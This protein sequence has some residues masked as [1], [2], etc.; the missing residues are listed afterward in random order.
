MSSDFYVYAYLDPRKPGEYKYG[1]L[2]FNYEPFYIGKGR[3]NRINQHL[4]LSRTKIEKNVVKARTIKK[5]LKMGFDLKKNFIV[6]IKENI[7]EDES[8]ALEMQYVKC[9]G[10]KNIKT[11]P[12]LN[13][14]DGGD[15]C[16]GM[17]VR[18]ETRELISRKNKG[19][20]IKEETRKKNSINNAKYWTGKIRSKK[21]IK[22][23]KSARNK[24]PKYLK[25]I[26]N[27]IIIDPNGKEY[28]TKN[29]LSDFCK[30]H[31]LQRSKMVLVA[32]G[33]R[34]HHRNWIC[35]Y[36]E[37]NNM[38][39]SLL[40][41]DFY[42]FT[43]QQL[44]FH[45]FHNVDV[46]YEFKC[47]SEKIDFA[48]YF[49]EIKEKINLLKNLTLTSREDRFMRKQFVFKNNY[50]DFI[51]RYNNN[52]NNIETT[53]E[54][55]G[56]LKIVISG[57]WLNTV[58]LEV[59]ILAIVNEIYFKDKKHDF[60]IGMERLQKKVDL[61]KNIK[62]FKFADFGT[63][64]RL[65]YKWQEKVIEFLKE[66]CPDNFIGTSN[67]HFAHKYD[68]KPIGTMSHQLI[69][70]HQALVRVEDSQK[71]A[72][73]N[74]VKEYE[75]KLGIAL[76]DTCGIDAFLKDFSYPLASVYSGIRQDSGDPFV[77]AEK[78]IEHYKSLGIDPKTKTIVF[79]DGL[80]FPL[81][82]KLYKKFK[83]EIN[84]IFGIGTD[85]T[86]AFQHEP[87]QIVIKMVSC[88]N[89][90][91]AKISEARGKTMCNDSV[92]LAYLK[93]VFNIE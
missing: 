56:E 23:L 33:K 7:T 93:N 89:Q 41:N 90:P 70:A 25:K 61:I 38:I 16:S 44:I 21:T 18:K 34:K 40:D 10:R 31:G 35:K 53:L 43:Q 91:V 17:L 22:A 87:L 1:N 24:Q 65:S 51:D 69:M 2:T 76:S 12:L 9:I 64:R 3:R 84:I 47:R 68:L 71:E 57:K 92:Y 8:K 63:R 52:L 26:M 50:I 62:G 11:G 45:Q 83:D 72:L 36:G 66:K 39:N 88:N 5:L 28:R 29:G 15:G 82:I 32:Q 30:E 77:V 59:P 20:E 74:W 27:Y 55:N 54:Q 73:W 6:K 78:V 75:G 13:L 85:L 42:T 79:S 80:N 81:A 49:E 48:P 37:G 58:S 86:G 19:K 4:W 46:V 60:K 67:V 14:T